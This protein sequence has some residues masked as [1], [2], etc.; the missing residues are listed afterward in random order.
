MSF[1]STLTQ[2]DG[3]GVSINDMSF[4][5]NWTIDNRDKAL[6]ETEIE[7]GLKSSLVI[8][9]FDRDRLDKPAGLLHP[10][11]VDSS[12]TVSTGISWLTKMW[13]IKKIIKSNNS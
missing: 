11:A 13:T 6:N 2:F 12:H 7:K 3:Q 1:S 4:S 5:L 8:Y 10:V 9:Q